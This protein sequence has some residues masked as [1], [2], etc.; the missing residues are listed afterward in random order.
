MGKKRPDPTI[1]LERLTRGYGSVMGL[2][3]V[4]LNIYPGVTGLLGPNGA[5]KSTMMKVLTGLMR[6]GQG[7][8]K[9]LGEPPFRNAALM[10]RIG[11]CPEWDSFYREMS[12]FEFVSF[13][14]RMHGI[15]KKKAEDLAT[16]ALVMVEL[17]HKMDEPIATYSKGMR[18]RTKVAQAIVHDPDVILLDEPLSGTDPVG[19]K[20][21]V[22]LIRK[23]G[24]EGKTIVV[25]S[26]ILHE[27]EVMT[28]NIVMI[29]RG[30]VL[31]EGEIQN[32]RD[33][34]DQQ[35]HHIVIDCDEPRKFA[36]AFAQ[37]ED[38]TQIIFTDKG[39]V[40]ATSAPDRCYERIP[41]LAL[42][43]KVK[44]RALTCSD[45]DLTAVFRYLIG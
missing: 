24:E 9:V 23:M 5:G 18:Q 10:R 30:K 8:V 35:P 13:L 1:V 43:Q 7:S 37:F 34:I 2:N 28:R 26:H 4:S 40:I 17:A 32:I 45:N 29:H 3:D 36:T 27:I 15:E 33:M 6:P 21:I 31:A 19:R 38:I 44:I 41:R 42:D 25:S 14:T 11:F 20:I 16:K 12:G 22:D 39:F